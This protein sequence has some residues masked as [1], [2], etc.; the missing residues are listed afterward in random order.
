MNIIDAAQ[1]QAVTSYPDLVEWLRESHLDTIDAMD[2]LL[3]TQPAAAGG[4]DTLLIRAA[5]QR[6]KQIGVKLITVFPGQRRRGAAV[7]S[8]R[9]HALRRRQRQAAREPRRHRAHV[10]ENGRGLRARHSI[11]RPRGRQGAVHDRGGRAGPA[12]HQCALLG[13]AVDRARDDLEPD[14]RQSRSARRRGAGGGRDVRSDQ[15]HRG[16]VPRRRHHH[17]RDRGRGAAGARATGCGP[18]STWIWSADTS[19]RCAKRIP[20]RSSVRGCSWTHGRPRSESAATS[21]SR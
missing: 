1:M 11:P 8:S 18:A 7:H 13:A 21:S 6:G 2:D 20:K 4:A 10:L 17:H 16:R 3:M 19:P 15:R 14:P 5:W 12:S 9:V